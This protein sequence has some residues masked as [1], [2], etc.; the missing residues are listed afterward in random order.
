M[1]VEAGFYFEVD[2]REFPTFAARA[3]YACLQAVKEFP[4]DQIIS[5]FLL[6]TGEAEFDGP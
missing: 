3:E 5:V 6:G 1:G 2:D 4:S